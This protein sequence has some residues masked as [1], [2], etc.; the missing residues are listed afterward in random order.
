MNFYTMEIY[1][2]NQPHQPVVFFPSTE[3]Q[4]THLRLRKTT[5]WGGTK[6]HFGPQ[7][8]ILDPKGPWK[9]DRGV[10]FWSPKNDGFQP[11]QNKGC[12]VGGWT[13]PFEKYANRQIGSFPQF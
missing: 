9:I 10:V 5:P 2:I 6:V 4:T 1:G 13:N 8:S 3:I 7:R 11:P 12:L